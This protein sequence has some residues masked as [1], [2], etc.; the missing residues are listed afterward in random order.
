[1]KTDFQTEMLKQLTRIA[2]ALDHRNKKKKPQP[3]SR[4]PIL[5]DWLDEVPLDVQQ[6]WVELFKD[7]LWVEAELKKAAVWCQTN[8]WKRVP[9]DNNA[10]FGLSWLQRAQDTLKKT[11]HGM[12]D[13]KAKVKDQPKPMPLTHDVVDNPDGTTSVVI[14]PIANDMRDWTRNAPWERD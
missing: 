7:K 6:S 8:P 3:I 11:A 5:T 12:Q 9:G 14:K 10:R 4:D 2:D 1:M 13:V